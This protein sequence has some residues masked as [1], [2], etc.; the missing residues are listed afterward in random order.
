MKVFA[1]FL[2]ALTASAVAQTGDPGLDSLTAYHNAAEKSYQD[3]TAGMFARPLRTTVEFDGARHTLTV[4]GVRPE[5]L[6]VQADVVRS[7]PKERLGLED[8]VRFGYGTPDEVAAVTKIRAERERARIEAE[9]LDLERRRTEAIE[10]AV[11]IR[12]ET[13]H[14]RYVREEA[15]RRAARQ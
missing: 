8:R 1:L 9:R 4:L 5:G 3:R 10:A 15:A 2:L 14:E 6:I 13:P 11:G 12:P 7:I